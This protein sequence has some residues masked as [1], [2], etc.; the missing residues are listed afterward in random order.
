VNFL[1]LMKDINNKYKPSKSPQ[2]ISKQW[3]LSRFHRK[4]D[5]AHTI[6]A[7]IKHYAVK[8]KP[9][10]QVKKRNNW[11]SNQK[12]KFE[13]VTFCTWENLKQFTDKSLEL[14]RKLS[15]FAR[16]KVNLQKSIVS[17][18]WKKQFEY[19]LHFKRRHFQ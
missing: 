15:Y 19:V 5:G 2:L 17:L 6:P 12:R 3:K 18:L 16:H 10:W 9:V 4:Q 14:K 13:S 8:Y 1:S 7:W 11:Q